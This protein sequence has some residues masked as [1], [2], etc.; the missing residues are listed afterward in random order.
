MDFLGGLGRFFGNIFNDKPKKK[1]EEQQ[2]ISTPS[3][4][5][6]SARDLSAPKQL[7]R[8]Q[9]SPLTLSSLDITRPTPQPKP[10]SPKQPSQPSFL[11]GVGGFFKDIG[12]ALIDG[13]RKFGGGLAG[14]A[15]TLSGQADRDQQAYEDANNSIQ[16]SQRALARM[17]ND[18]TDLARQQRARQALRTTA[19][20]SRTKSP[21]E[22]AQE[23][24]DPRKALV[25]AA[26]TGLDILTAGIG[27]KLLGSGFKLATGAGRLGARD[28]ATELSKE[29]LQNAG[30]GGLY[31]GISTAVDPD[32]TL[33][34]YLKNIGVGAGFGVGGGLAARGLGAGAGVALNRA[35]NSAESALQP[36][37]VG[38]ILRE[39]RRVGVED[40]TPN[41]SEIPALNKNTPVVNPPRTSDIM[42]DVRPAPAPTPEPNLV[43]DVSGGAKTPQ[44]GIV[45]QQPPTT[46]PRTSGRMDDVRLGSSTSPE[47]ITPQELQAEINAVRNDPNL[48]TSQKN[49]LIKQ[50]N[51]SGGTR[52]PVKQQVEVKTQVEQPEIKRVETDNSVDDSPTITQQEV[53]KMKQQAESAGVTEEQLANV[54]EGQRE[55]FVA[56]Q[57]NARNTPV[58]GE[59]PSF[60]DTPPTPR[61]DTNVSSGGDPFLRRILETNILPDLGRAS[62]DLRNVKKLRKLDAAQ[63]SATQARLYNEAIERGLSPADAQA[64][65]RSA[66]KG[67][68]AKTEYRAS[69]MAKEDEAQ[70][71][72]MVD[73][74]L[75]NEGGFTQMN[76]RQSFLNLIHTGEDGYA[77]HIRPADLRNVRDWFNRNLGDGLGDGWEEYMKE[78][79]K[80]MSEDHLAIQLINTPRVLMASGDLGVL[81]RQGGKIG[82]LHPVRASQAF[83]KSLE[84]MFNPK[85]YQQALDKIS[86]NKNFYAVKDEMGYA[87]PAFQHGN[88]NGY[89]ED[90][91]GSGFIEKIPGI[92]SYVRAFQ[93]QY[94]Y[95]L[96]DLRFNIANDM[97][98][99]GGGI[100]AIR[101]AAQK[102]DDP[103]GYMKLYGE[104]TNTF[105]GRGDINGAITKHAGLLN[106]LF[107]SA[108]N[109]AAK[110]QMLNPFWYGKLALKNPA[111]AKEAAKLALAN[112]TLYAGVLAAA[113]QAGLVE[114]GKIK[115]GNTRIDITGGLMT[116]I[117]TINGSIEA[118][119]ND[120]K[121]IF[122]G[123]AADEWAQFFKNQLNPGI[124]QIVRFLSS[125]PDGEGGRV[126]QF[127]NKVSLLDMAANS[128]TPMTI[129]GAYDDLVNQGV[130]PA[131]AAANFAG[132]TIGLGVNT[133]Q[134]AADK[135]RADTEAHADEINAQASGL[136]QLGVFRNDTLKG[137]LDE[138]ATKL[139]DKMSSG[140]Q[141]SRKE[142]S[143]LQ[144]DLVKGV[145]T[146]LTADSDSAYRERGDYQT[147]WQTLNIK[148]QLLEQ[149]PTTKPSVIRNLEIQI[150]RTE[151]LAQN[152]I[153]YSDLELYQNT[154]LSEWRKLA[155]TNPAAYKKLAQI[156]QLFTNAGASYGSG[157]TTKNK[158]YDSSS[159]GKRRRNQFSGLA[160]VST[161]RSSWLPKIQQYDTSSLMPNAA[162]IPE[163]KRENPQ[164]VHKI[165]QG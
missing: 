34:D 134:T 8:P 86:K 2:N 103:D 153:P 97:I 25:G 154:S 75:K 14:A 6:P 24:T 73:D 36:A 142:I 89:A 48:T 102:S 70:L 164:I 145:S 19:N 81:T 125:K 152:D 165:T 106:G 104:V 126:D 28:L 139:W 114:D 15:Y 136:N 98:E 110:V 99:K 143:S 123:T 95:F 3:F 68:Y 76:V 133:Y 22:L 163:I 112:A 37:K 20:I 137:L 38:T 124:G 23:M 66:L 85:E 53:A 122:S 79:G 18:P 11:D 9:S 109:L 156:D 65:S 47:T 107:F 78:A 121:N 141:L 5:I 63:R 31:G 91:L 41:A 113:N 71:F 44:E 111:A 148:K 13:E 138:D 116:L 117:N 127:G 10:I 40:L 93:R 29:G 69:P 146:G 30:V 39:L 1:K 105:S 61:L 115:I 151:L 132:N 84:V 155:D 140:E 90:F 94:D 96:T 62:A 33:G 92:G 147:D 88:K 158:Y 80:K 32:A 60:N 58:E 59:T 45:P 119:N 108:P 157:D 51:A 82:L 77:N 118:Y 135:E 67:E 74:S 131:Q 56:A 49:D 17:A 159:G 7:S 52:I 55:D 4:S 16:Q 21:Y 83:K 35:L 162:K 42:D 161:D 130:S 43:Q 12:G 54:P 160:S 144:N 26:E 120:D 128:V 101:K 87:L 50:L 100:D 72:K 150:K 129:S 64:Y 149:D 57:A 27:S 46:P